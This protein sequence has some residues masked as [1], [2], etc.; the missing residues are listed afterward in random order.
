M[1]TVAGVIVEGISGMNIYD[2]YKARGW[3][4]KRWRRYIEG[5]E[6]RGRE[7]RLNPEHVCG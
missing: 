7:D 1:C 2:I 3:C 6:K 5:G 4:C